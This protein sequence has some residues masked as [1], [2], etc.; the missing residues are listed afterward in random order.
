MSTDSSL[1]CEQCREAVESDKST[2]FNITKEKPIELAKFIQKHYQTC[3]GEF[4]MGWAQDMDIK[5]RI[6]KDVYARDAKRKRNKK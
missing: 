2:N 5:R 3:R 4:Y 6:N 1:F